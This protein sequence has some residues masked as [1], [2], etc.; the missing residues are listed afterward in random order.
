MYA[1]MRASNEEK[2]LSGGI[3]FG[4]NPVSREKINPVITDNPSMRE[5]SHAFCGCLY[6]STKENISNNKTAD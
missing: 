1:G 6:P 2:I 3:P 5:Y 4:T